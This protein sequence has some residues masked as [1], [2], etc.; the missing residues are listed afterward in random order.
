MDY[1]EVA[2]YILYQQLFAEPNLIRD[3]RSL[4]KIPVE[5]SDIIIKKMLDLVLADIQMW[6]EGK[7]KDYLSRLAK[8]IGFNANKI[9][10]EFH[11]RL[12]PIPREQVSNPGFKFMLAIS[13]V[14]KTIHENATA[15]VIKSLEKKVKKKTELEI[16]LQ[17]L[18]EQNNLEFSLLLNLA[19]LKEYA[20]IVKAPYPLEIYYEYFEKILELLD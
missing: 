9:L 14:I 10:L 6:D 1:K 11:I 20:D 16:R 3:R 18:S 2:T 19:I 5:G 15:K 17:E 8:K 12:K 7:E 4:V 13:E